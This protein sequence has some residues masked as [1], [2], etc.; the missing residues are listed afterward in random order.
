MRNFGENFS[1]FISSIIGTYS[2]ENF[3]TII[4]TILL[5]ISILNI[6]IVLI[7]KICRYL[8]N[9]GK[10]D[11]EEAKDIKKDLIEIADNVKKLNKEGENND[12]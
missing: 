10:I 12:K 2:L 3:N 8:K 1:I 4:D 9:D 11:K 6:S 5:I 7:F